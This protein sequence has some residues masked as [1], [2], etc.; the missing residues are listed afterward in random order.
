MASSFLTSS[1]ASGFKNFSMS[2][3]ESAPCLV[4]SAPGIA[5]VTASGVSGIEGS[6]SSSFL[7]NGMFATPLTAPP[8]I[9]PLSPALIN[10]SKFFS[11]KK[12]LFSSTNFSAAADDISWTASVAPSVANP[13][14]TPLPARLY[15]APISSFSVRPT[16]LALRS[17]VIGV[18]ASSTE[19]KPPNR[20]AA[21]R[22]SLPVS[23]A[24]FW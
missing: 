7:P 1:F 2:S 18:M 22:S 11:V 21:P 12:F 24:I 14:N 15:H 20:R 16:P 6:G 3:S 10:R 8:P 4:G 23:S 17:K 13:V 19:L 9:P 5:G